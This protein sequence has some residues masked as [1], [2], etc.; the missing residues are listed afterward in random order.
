M[1]KNKN[2]LGRSLNSILSDI[3][4]LYISNRYISNTEKENA[5]LLEGNKNL[6]FSVA[7]E[8]SDAKDSMLKQYPFDLEKIGAILK[9]ERGKR[10]LS[11]EEISKL[12]NLR[13]PIIEAIE[14]GFWERLPHEVYVR[15]YVKE[16]A[17]ILKIDHVILPHLNIKRH[18]SDYSVFLND[19]KKSDKKQI[20]LNKTSS[21]FSRTGFL[22]T[23]AVVLIAFAFIFL[24]IN[25]ENKENEKLEKAVQISNTVNNNETQQ[26]LP[27][28]SSNKKL[29]ITCHERT[30][31]S[32]I[33]D[34]KEKKEFILNPGEVV[35]LNAKERFDILVGNAGGIKFLLNG[36]DVEFSGV[37]GQ[38]KRITL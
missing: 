30:W 13:R 14:N 9:E 32:V 19:D 21:L 38:V 28:L 26:Q 33:M 10:S 20:V 15:G 31:I 6:D 3:N 11:I 18:N 7:E 27:V 29:M 12:L 25:K 22:Y 36:K 1:K 35:I 4:G 2:R 5:H 37:S 8:G 34:G 16:Y 24:N 23:M 17:S